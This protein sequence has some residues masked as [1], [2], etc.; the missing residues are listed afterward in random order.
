M[1]DCTAGMTLSSA[2]CAISIF[3]AVL[4]CENVVGA[5]GRQMDDD[6]K[7]H[8]YSFQGVKWIFDHSFDD[9]WQENQSSVL[10][11]EQRN[12]RKSREQELI[13]HYGHSL[14]ESKKK[15]SSLE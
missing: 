6:R 9:F 8:R 7:T 15:V 13:T 4:S 1:S 10:F 2:A 14:H 12:K 5:R 3:G 11:S